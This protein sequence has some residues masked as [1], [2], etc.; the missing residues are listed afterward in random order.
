MSKKLCK[1]IA[2]EVLNEIV[3]AENYSKIEIMLMQQWNDGQ[4]KSIKRNLFFVVPT[5]E[6]TNW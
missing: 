6:E 4:L 1:Q 3:N 5:L 2:E